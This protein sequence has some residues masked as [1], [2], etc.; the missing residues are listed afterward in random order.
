MI[1]GLMLQVSTPV[2]PAIAQDLGVKPVV[3]RTDPKTGF[4]VGGKNS[5]SVI[6]TLAEI[7]GRP[8][9]ELERDMRPGADAVE[10]SDAGFL[11]AD[12]GLREVMASDNQFVVDERKLTH[13]EL[14]IHLRIL[15][16]LGAK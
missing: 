4:V 6:R 8:I 13:Q 1:M 15:A 3:P 16:V 9:A 10:G 11:G 14:A 2:D 7:N 5:T 12:E